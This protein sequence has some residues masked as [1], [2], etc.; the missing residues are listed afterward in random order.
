MRRRLKE[1]ILSSEVVGILSVVEVHTGPEFIER[2]GKERMK[3]KKGVIIFEQIAVNEQYS[4]NIF[5]FV[6]SKEYKPKGWGPKTQAMKVLPLTKEEQKKYTPRLRRR[7][8][9]PLNFW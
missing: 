9:G 6:K 4:S 1:L 7:L 2:F 5:G 3:T 8:K